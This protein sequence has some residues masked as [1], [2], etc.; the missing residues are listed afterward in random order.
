MENQHLWLTPL[1]V[2]NNEYTANPHYVVPNEDHV[3]TRYFF[4]YAG[5]SAPS[6]CVGE[7]KPTFAG[8][9]QQAEES[10]QFPVEASDRRTEE[11]RTLQEKKL[12]S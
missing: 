4:I 3:M 7:F 10:P 6:V 2:I 11:L 8:G 9:G 12:M 5:S 1:A